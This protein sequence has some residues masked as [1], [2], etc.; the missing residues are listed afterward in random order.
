MYVHQAKSSA[1]KQRG[2][3][4]SP[5]V[6]KPAHTETLSICGEQLH[7]AQ[8]GLPATWPVPARPQAPRAARGRSEW[9]Q[10]EAVKGEGGE[11]RVSTAQPADWGFGEQIRAWSALDCH[12]ITLPGLKLRWAVRR[13]LT[14]EL[15]ARWIIYQ[16]C[17]SVMSWHWCQADNL[18]KILPRRIRIARVHVFLGLLAIWAALKA[19]WF[20]TLPTFQGPVSRMAL[21]STAW[22]NLLSDLHPFMNFWQW[23]SL[24]FP[25]DLQK[26]FK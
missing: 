1:P 21:G 5:P 17:P 8:L 6:V 12:H 18:V 16:S 9:S 10:G 15:S 2:M 13:L 14:T 7:K 19:M 24:C 23:L 20:Y 3:E 22:V 11:S 25:S 4:R 26:P